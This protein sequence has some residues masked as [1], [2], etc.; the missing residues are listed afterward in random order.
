M[1]S[2]LR[3]TKLPVSVTLGV[4]NCVCSE[5]GWFLKASRVTFPYS[6][7]LCSTSFLGGCISLVFGCDMGYRSILKVRATGCLV[8]CQAKSL[9]MCM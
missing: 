1:T 2:G 8:N 7:V 5:D 4:R 3:N 9:L 6:T